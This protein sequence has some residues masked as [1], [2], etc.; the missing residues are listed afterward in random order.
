MLRFRVRYRR[1]ITISDDFVFETIVYDE[2]KG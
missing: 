2:G 1:F